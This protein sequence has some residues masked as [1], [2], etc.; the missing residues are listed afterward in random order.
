MFRII[1]VVSFRS[2]LVRIMA[3]GQPRRQPRLHRPLSTI[4]PI[5]IWA[6]ARP[7]RVG[8]VISGPPTAQWDQEGSGAEAPTDP[9]PH[10]T[11]ATPRG[12]LGH[13]TLTR[14]HQRPPIHRPSSQ[15]HPCQN[16][17]AP[18][19]TSNWTRRWVRTTINSFFTRSLELL[20]FMNPLF[21]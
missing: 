8:V 7:T 6:R 21:N 18:F 9:D 15:N 11:E 16:S 14:G 12:D 1:F 4:L 10:P 19:Y 20:V 3:T 5:R 17:G 2:T 13:Q